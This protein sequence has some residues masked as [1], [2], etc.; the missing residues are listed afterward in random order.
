MTVG[1]LNYRMNATIAEAREEAK[2]KP[3]AEALYMWLKKTSL[4]SENSSHCYPVADSS[5]S[6]SATRNRTAPICLRRGPQI[7]T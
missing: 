5:M 1:K 2:V 3:A 4:R 6:H 7:C